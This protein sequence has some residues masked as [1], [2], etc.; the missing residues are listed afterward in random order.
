MSTGASQIAHAVDVVRERWCDTPRVALILG[1]GM[2][3]LADC[4]QSAVS[5]PYPDIPGFPKPTAL[6][7]K[8]QLV[9]GKLSGVDIVAMQGRCHLYEGYSVDEITLPV[10]VMQALGATTLI[11]GN[12]SGAVNPSYTT[13]DIMIIADHIDLMWQR[14]KFQTSEVS[15]TSE[16][17]DRGLI[18][19][20]LAIA[21]RED[22][23]AHRGVYVAVPGPSYETRAEY[24][25][26]RK[27]G[28]DV[29]GMSTVPEVIVAS[30]LGMRILGLST[31]TNVAIPD[32]PQK[33]D[34]NEVVEAVE[35]AAR[36]LESIVT[37]F[38]EN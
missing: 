19:Q 6:A 24:R 37:G 31:V 21:R 11:V 34:A 28:G 3:G 27:I 10:R 20:S 13:G 25:L 38:V 9:C 16:V 5:V 26:F 2:G 29:V 7:H 8:G 35:Q 30:N 15:K 22:F 18:E 14:Y 36:K 23:V 32:A 4:I 1:T 17:Y 33:T 12:A